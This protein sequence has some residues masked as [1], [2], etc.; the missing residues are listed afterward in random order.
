VGWKLAEA[1]LDNMPAELTSGERCVVHAIA[2]SIKDATGE[3]WV[4][5]PTLLQRSGLSPRGIRKALERLAERGYELRI[6]IDKDKHG[7]PV[8]AH[9]GQARQFRFPDEWRPVDNSQ[10]G[11]TPVPPNGE[12]GGTPVPERR[13]PSTGKAVPQ[14]R[15]RGNG[16][17]GGNSGAVP[18]IGTRHAPDCACHGSGLEENDDGMP[19]GRPCPVSHLR[20][21]TA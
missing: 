5:E 7:Q 16:G 14:Y 1:A 17:N 10:K 4:T 2:W 21:V 20:A 6:A 13:Y 11:G 18:P 3:G 8:Y 15:P 19:T 9:R 12:K